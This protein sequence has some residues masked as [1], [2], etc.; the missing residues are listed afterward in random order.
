[1]T[2]DGFQTHHTFERKGG[3]SHAS[4][5]SPAL[6]S[7]HFAS[8]VSQST[9]ESIQA[10]KLYQAFHFLQRL[11]A[12]A[13]SFHATLHPQWIVM[14]RAGAKGKQTKKGANPPHNKNQHKTSRLLFEINTLQKLRCEVVEDMVRQWMAMPWANQ[15]G[16]NTKQQKQ[17]PKHKK[18]QTKTRP[19][20]CVRAGLCDGL[21]IAVPNKS[22]Q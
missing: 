21:C 1:M 19:I 6:S 15:Q 13:R 17:P 7:R 20:H 16:P 4:S 11:L 22:Q 2:S 14:L 10:C 8:K 12:F 3:L 5:C 18:H 9:S